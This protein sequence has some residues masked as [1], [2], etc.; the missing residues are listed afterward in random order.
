M[1]ERKVYSELLKW[2]NREHKCLV[3]TGQRQ[4]GKSYIIDLFGKTEYERYIYIN[5]ASMPELKQYFEGDQTAESLIQK[6]ILEFGSDSIKEGNTLLFLDEIQECSKAYASLKQFT[7]YGKIDVICSGSLLGVTLPQENNVLIP[8]GYEERL[9]MY[10]LDFEEFLWANKIPKETIERVRSCIREKTVIEDVIFNKFSELFRT[11]MIVGGMPE[12]VDTFLKT[13]D[14]RPA[15]AILSITREICTRDINRYNSNKEAAKT[16]EC[17]ESIPNQLSESNKKFM[18][19]RINGEG[20]R[21]S[22]QRYMENLLWI[23]DAGY[24]NFCYAVSQPTLPLKKQIKHD[25]FKVYLSDTGML[26]DSYGDKAKAAI[27]KGDTSY[28]LGAVVENAIAEALMKNDITPTFYRKDKG[29]A[30]MEIDFVLEFWDGVA[31]IEVK[32]GKHKSANSIHKIKDYFPI[33]RRIM[34]ETGNIFIDSDCIEHYPL[35]A[36]TFIKVMNPRPEDMNFSYD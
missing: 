26:L 6:L 5:F 21:M 23:K 19:S 22:S 16:R 17:F 18:Y 15:E 9:R 12:V 1:L 24:G 32:S 25:N 2:K 33:S 10:A 27:Y 13:K 35:F 30:R 34:F 11:F 20:T 3:V 7:T 14:F 4:V 8:L 29:D 36:A 28:N 31:A